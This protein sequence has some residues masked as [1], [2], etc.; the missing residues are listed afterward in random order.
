MVAF[1]GWILYC[2]ALGIAVVIANPSTSEERM[3]FLPFALIGMALP[4][5]VTLI[6]SMHSITEEAGKQT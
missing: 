1:W 4:V 6:A 5:V 3:F 2:L